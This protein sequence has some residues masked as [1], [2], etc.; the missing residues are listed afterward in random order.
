MDS[1]ITWPYK[2]ADHNCRITWVYNELNKYLSNLSS[3]HVIL[4]VADTL[5][6]VSAVCYYVFI[7]EGRA[8][9]PFEL[10][11]EDEPKEGSDCVIM[12]LSH[13]QAYW[14]TE[15]C[16]QAH[17][18]VCQSKEINKQ[19]ILVIIEHNLLALEHHNESW[20]FALFN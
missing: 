5:S 17:Y 4:Q 9:P 20:L 2:I 13:G 14:Y 11:G 7:S 18:T 6:L 8:S 12:R 19:N 1:Y 16:S 15:D 3:L 10:W